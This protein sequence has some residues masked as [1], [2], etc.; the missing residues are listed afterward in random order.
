MNFFQALGLLTVL[1]GLARLLHLLLGRLLI[2]LVH[3]VVRAKH[4]SGT[5]H[6]GAFLVHFERGHRCFKQLKVFF[7][8]IHLLLLFLI[9]GSG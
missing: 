1:V 7:F 5:L 8:L 3:M 2:G 4:V 9:F 6:F